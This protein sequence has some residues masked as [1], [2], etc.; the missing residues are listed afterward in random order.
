MFITFEGIDGSGKTTLIKKLSKWLRSYGYKV[1]TT[2][3]P[4][5]TIFGKK[6]RKILLN[7]KIEILSP[8]TSLLLYSADRLEHVYSTI[9]DSLDEGMVVLCDRYYDSTYAYQHH[10][11]GIPLVIVDS[12]TNITGVDPDITI[13]LDISPEK[14]LERLDGK[15]KNESRYEIKDLEF[16]NKIRYGYLKRAEEFPDRIKVINVDG[17]SIEDV[18]VAAKDEISK[19]LRINWQKLKVTRKD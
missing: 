9:L 7:P 4:G 17:A 8:L 2:K 13:L 16:K 18:F 3:E 5:G 14:V 19:K 6:I 12:L 15:C 10:A 1:K 11:C